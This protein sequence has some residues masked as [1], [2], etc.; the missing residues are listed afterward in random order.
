MTCGARHRSDQVRGRLRGRWSRRQGHAEA[1]G[2]GRT[3]RPQENRSRGRLPT[4]SPKIFAN[5]PQLSIFGNTEFLTEEDTA[6]PNSQCGYIAAHES[7]RELRVGQQPVAGRRGG[8]AQAISITLKFRMAITIKKT[9]LTRFRRLALDEQTAEV[10][11]SPRIRKPSGSSCSGATGS[12]IL[13][14]RKT[15]ACRPRAA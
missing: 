5:R 11:A 3:A 9:A 10:S 2:G 1:G 14:T 12:G 15:H 13:G 4:R 6:I 8:G 7:L